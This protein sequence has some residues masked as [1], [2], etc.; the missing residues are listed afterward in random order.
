MVERSS[1]KSKKVVK[2][3]DPTFTTAA[4]RKDALGDV[5]AINDRHLK[6]IATSV[7]TLFEPKRILGGSDW[8]ACQKEKGQ[9]VE[10]YGNSK[11]KNVLKAPRDKIYLLIAHPY[12][13]PEFLEK[14]KLYVGAFYGGKEC[15]FVIP[16]D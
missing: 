1:S 15:K 5:R 3:Q 11:V 13:S 6:K 2:K 16:D 8:L 7:D 4:K 9:T 12:F 10:S 14:L